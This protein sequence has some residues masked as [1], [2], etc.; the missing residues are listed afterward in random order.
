MEVF[1]F[2]F[3]KIGLFDIIDIVLVA[4]II[5][6]IYNLIRGTIAV[7]IFIGL[8]CVYLLWLL[9]KSLHMQL[10]SGILDKVIGLGAI[11]LIVVFQQEIRRFL[12][13][14]GKNTFSNKN[15]LWRKLFLSN[16][17]AQKTSSLKI[18][19]VLEACKNMS[20]SRT[21]GLIVFAR[22]FEEHI[23]LNNGEIL[24]ARISRRLIETIFSKSSPLHDGAVV[25]S[26]N[27]IKAA[28]CI[29]P[30]TDN[31]EL[32]SQL[33]LRHRAGVGITEHS[34]AVA[35]I[36]SEETGGIS[37]AARGKVKVNISTSDLEKFLTRDFSD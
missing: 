13:I 7:N 30:L 6:Q 37:Y 2:G 5:Y 3:L 34:D 4:L 33:G 19:P 15:S 32:P 18:R 10:L 28:S 21:G 31:T 29:L 14:I 27:L 23:F 9:V 26:E 24:N 35:V 36:V 16:Q 22:T 11:A 20:K 1:D 12:L 25:I 8:F 17:S